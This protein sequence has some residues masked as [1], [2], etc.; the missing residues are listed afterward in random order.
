MKT[1]ENAQYQKNPLNGE[2]SCITV[3]IDGDQAIV[4]LDPANTDYANL[5]ELEREGKIVIQPAD[6]E[7]E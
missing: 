5:M 3:V 6:G 2:V 7:T 4:P 1:Y